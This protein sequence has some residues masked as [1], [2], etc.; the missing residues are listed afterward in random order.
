MQEDNES[1]STASWKNKHGATILGAILAA[2]FA[3]VMTVQ[4][5]C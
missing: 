4:V 2:L 5:A 3:I 1:P